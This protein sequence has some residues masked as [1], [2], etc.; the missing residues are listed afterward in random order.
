MKHTLTLVDAALEYAGSGYRIFPL[1]AGSKVPR[2]G[3]RGCLD[4]T[5]D[6]ATVERWWDECPQANIGLSTDG[7]CVV[8]IDGVQWPPEASRAAD[9]ACASAIA[10][11]P[12]G[13]THYLFRAPAGV[14][15][16]NSQGNK[17]GLAPGVDI[18]GQGGYIVVAPS[19]AYGRPY[20]WSVAP[21]CGPESLA[22]APAWLLD[23]I[24]A[25]GK[26]RG[27]S[28]NVASA[29]PSAP[30]DVVQRAELYL[31]AMPP[32][33]SGQGGHSQTYAAAVSLVHGF[34]LADDQ[35]L[36]LLAR[37]YNP[38]CVPPW[39]ER[40][41][42]H[43]VREAG[44]KPHE[45]P[46]GWLRDPVATSGVDLSGIL[47]QA[48]AP[49]APAA[50]VEAVEKAPV[51]PPADMLRAPGFVGE[52]MDYTLTTAPYPNDVMAF[53]GALSMLAFLAGRKFRDPGDNR[54]N[55]YLLGLAQSAAG[56]DH[57]RKV[58]ARIMADIG[59]GAALGDRFASG[60]GIQDALLQT[61]CMLFQTDEIDG[62]F[63]A[64]NRA[65]DARH[66]SIMGTLLSMYSS[67]NGVFPVRRKAAQEG[68]VMIE[69]PCLVMFGTAIP[70]HYYDALSERMLTNGLL[71][72]MLIIES[73]PRGRGQ[74]PR[75][76]PI[77]PRVLA[78]AQWL[79][80]YRPT[81]GNLAHVHPAPSTVE[82]TADAMQAIGALRCRTD[83]E[84][85]T[86]E[87]C[88]D[89]VGCTVWGRV[90]ETARK[91]ALLWAISENHEAPRITGRAVEWG[92]ALAVRQA[93]GML[94]AATRG[95]AT[96]PFHAECLRLLRRV[97]EAGGAITRQLLIRR[98][99]L[100]AR[101]LDAIVTTLVESGE[102]IAEATTGG[103]GR[104]AIMYRLGT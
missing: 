12:R 69:Q 29:R 61:P 50:P 19:M 23:D 103:V 66:E 80:D 36:D 3:S 31:L 40:E 9:L 18:R 43:K 32:A 92:A 56:K 1:L 46:F 21:N 26:E 44:K 47:A 60:E 24:A 10:R 35:A 48:G 13:G 38:R 83:D 104:P 63:L 45:K 49:A 6:E 54:T 94:S 84:Y 81:P 89:T 76:A 14:E 96:S 67:A 52:L 74:E 78:T 5:A 100:D 59:Q 70:N 79:A 8:D 65:K 22:V 68:A 87:E 11:T 93:R 7:L 42:V 82:A 30:L 4:A 102:L 39:S 85:A 27:P 77:P 28:V 72:R 57:P 25:L 51:A 71:A 15:I 37:C 20:E 16:A 75:P 58:N 73:G 17:G 34:G 53:C 91:L 55:L 2:G 97:Q 98:L 95:V 62:M 101:T 99:H 41:L 90:S 86:A 88:G 64:V 33:Y